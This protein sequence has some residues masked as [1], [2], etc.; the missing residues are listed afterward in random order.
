MS[1]RR[2]SCG[3]LKTWE[4]FLIAQPCGWVGGRWVGGGAG[5]E[6]RAEDVVRGGWQAY[7]LG[8]AV[9]R[10]ADLAVGALA[11]EGPDLVSLEDLE[12]VAVCLQLKGQVLD[13]DRVRVF[14]FVRR[15]GH[16]DGSCGVVG[17]LWT[18]TLPASSST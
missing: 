5:E 9:E 11:D 16:R 7:R 2:A 12:L 18:R 8:L 3:F 17:S 13:R 14:M 10:A 15:E 1:V 4:I 6:A